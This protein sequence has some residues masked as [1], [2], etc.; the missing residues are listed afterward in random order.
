MVRGRW[1]SRRAVL[2]SA[3]AAAVAAEYYSIGP[4]HAKVEPIRFGLTPVFLTSDLAL[5]AGLQAYLEHA[6]RRPVQ[7][8]NRRTYQ[9]SRHFSSLASWMPL[10]SAAIRS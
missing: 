1:P 3:T 8:F 6:T 10:G 4:A 9:K 2:L 5:L 7:L